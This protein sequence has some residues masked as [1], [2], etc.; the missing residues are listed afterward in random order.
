M[1]GSD[2]IEPEMSFEDEEQTENNIRV[3]PETPCELKEISDM[4][5]SEPDS[6]QKLSVSLDRNI[7]IAISLLQNLKK[8]NKPNDIRLQKR[9]SGKKG[10][11]RK[12]QSKM[13]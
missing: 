9:K 4:V 3:E 5:L 7:W 12:T 10:Q 1:S 6:Q 13:L 11:L 8:E 2:V